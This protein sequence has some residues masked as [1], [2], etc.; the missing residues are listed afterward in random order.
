MGNLQESLTWE[1]LLDQASE[2][3]IG[4]GDFYKLEQGDNE[5]RIL[6]FPVFNPTY[7]LDNKKI[8]KDEINK[9]NKDKVKISKKFLMYVFCQKEKRIKI[10]DFPW[11]ITKPIGEFQKSSQYSFKGLPPFDVII[12]RTGIGQTDTKYSV[13]PGRNEQPLSKE[14]MDEL[15]GKQ[16]LN[17]YLAEKNK[18]EESNPN[19][20]VEELEAIFGKKA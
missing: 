11:S 15:A 3:G 4:S 10:A 1:N 20:T 17:E 2:L 16:D 19:A 9:D 7:W 14:I 8:T 6:S 12:K 13:I 18:N 5:V